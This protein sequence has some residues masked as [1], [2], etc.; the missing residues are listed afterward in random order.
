MVRIG[1][2]TRLIFF[3]APCI[4]RMN[5][6]G[7]LKGYCVICRSRSNRIQ[8][9]QNC[10][11]N[12]IA[13]SQQLGNWNPSDDGDEWVRCRF[14]VKFFRLYPYR[15]PE[16]RKGP[17]LRIQSTCASRCGGNKLT[18]LGNGKGKPLMNSLNC[19]QQCTTSEVSSQGT[20]KYFK[21]HWAD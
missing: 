16:L 13:T 3:G 15:S 5:G 21:L 19:D 10:E 8:W 9:Q 7:Q 14:S 20:G 4:C 1:K 2:T 17:C 6:Q 12:R 18:S 11:K